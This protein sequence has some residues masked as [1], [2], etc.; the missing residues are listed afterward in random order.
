MN[1]PL[2]NGMTLKQI[3]KK[4]NLS[5]RTVEHHLEYIKIKLEC[6]LVFSGLPQLTILRYTSTI[7]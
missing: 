1:T 3:A 4:L 7:K 2:L 6:K 5:P